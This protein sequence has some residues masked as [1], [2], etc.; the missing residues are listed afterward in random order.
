MRVVQ[1]LAVAGMLSFAGM[2]HAGARPD[3]TKYPNLSKSWDKLEDA[4]THVEAAEKAHAKSG[5][6][7]GHGATA[8]KEIAAAEGEID[9][10]IQYAIAHTKP[11]APGKVTDAAAKPG[12][13]GADD[14]KYANLGDAHL[15]L[16]WSIIH[17]HQ[18]MEY[19]GPTGTL[20]GHGEKAEEHMKNAQKEILAA[21][22]FSDTAHPT[23]APVA[24]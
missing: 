16:E 23:A 12:A 19:H 18:A 24:K 2:A 20:G 8:Q 11:G 14:K 21:E 7:G 1:A 15:D 3:P 13:P 4:K 6:L 5:T 9:A 17:V 10:A 22:Q